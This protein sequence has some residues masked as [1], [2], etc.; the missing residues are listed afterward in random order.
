MCR[1]GNRIGNHP[2]RTAAEVS[3]RA[4]FIA[5]PYGVYP[6]GYEGH[7]RAYTHKAL[8]D[9]YKKWYVPNNATV[10]VIGPYDLEHV[11]PIFEEKF[12]KL[13]SKKLP[14]R[15][16]MPEPDREGLTTTVEQENPRAENIYIEIFYKV[17]TLIKNPQDFLKMHQVFS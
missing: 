3:R 1:V 12:G 13:T 16:R 4:Q 8:M 5:H 11:L 2:L 9:H 17:P 14:V 7:I 15:K 10:Y 6:I